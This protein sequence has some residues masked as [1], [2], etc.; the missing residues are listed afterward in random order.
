M[1]LQ[2]PLFLFKQFT[3]REIFSNLYYEQ[4]Y[5]L[6][7]RCLCLPR[8]LHDT[9]RKEDDQDLECVSTASLELTPGWRFGIESDA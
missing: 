3:P 2:L 1:I 9:D 4:L 7:R 6:S 5:L 8:L